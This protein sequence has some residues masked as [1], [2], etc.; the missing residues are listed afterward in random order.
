M[1]ISDMSD[2]WEVGVSMCIGGAEGMCQN[3]HVEI[4]GQL[5]LSSM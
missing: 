5:F 3:G 2:L 4:K 1:P